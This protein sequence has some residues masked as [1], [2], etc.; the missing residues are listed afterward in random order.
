MWLPGQPVWLPF[1]FCHSL[2]TGGRGL[3]FHH[4]SHYGWVTNHPK[5]HSSHCV[6]AHVVWAPLGSPPL[7]QS[8]RCIYSQAEAGTEVSSKGS[9]LMHLVPGLGRL[10]FPE[11][12]GW[13]YWGP[14]EFSPGWRLRDSPASLMEVQGSKD[15]CL[16]RGRT[17]R[18]L[19]HRD[20]VSEITWSSLFYSSPQN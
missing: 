6:T 4:H 3:D 10:T 15:P 17:R 7:P 16:K 20:L 1:W 11:R 12:E 19:Q 18:M 8:H 2:A 5:P 9:L 14:S 13:S